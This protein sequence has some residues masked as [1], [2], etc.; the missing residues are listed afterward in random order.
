MLSRSFGA[1]LFSIFWKFWNPIWGYC[2]PDSSLSVK[3]KNL[4]IRIPICPRKRQIFNHY[5]K[6]NKNEKNYLNHARCNTCGI[7]IY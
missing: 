5:N 2:L 1:Y 6:P 7:C 3:I 4:Y